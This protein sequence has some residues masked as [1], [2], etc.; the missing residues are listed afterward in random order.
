MFEAVLAAF[1]AI[2][3]IAEGIKELV[4]TIR[5]AQDAK[6]AKVISDIK[7]SNAIILKQIEGARTDE[8]LKKLIRDL[9]SNLNR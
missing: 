8:E 3:L 2:P 9:N 6:T 4:S 5:E 7:E 1:K